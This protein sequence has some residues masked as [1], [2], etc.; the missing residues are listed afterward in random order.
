MRYPGQSQ[1][2]H[3]IREGTLEVV[4]MDG[5]MV[6]EEEPGA[7]WPVILSTLADLTAQQCVLV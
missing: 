1:T 5:E 4:T 3:L 2:A 7:A 6:V